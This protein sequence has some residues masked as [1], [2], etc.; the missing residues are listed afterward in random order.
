[1]NINVFELFCLNESFLIFINNCK[2][3][4]SMRPIKY[5]NYIKDPIIIK[6][7]VTLIF[8]SF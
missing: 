5:F 6:Y 2:T 8:F 7:N 3:I 4:E 1:M